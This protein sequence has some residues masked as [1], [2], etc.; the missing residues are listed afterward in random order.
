MLMYQNDSFQTLT[1]T[2]QVGLLILSLVLL[3][4]TLWI[5]YRITKNR[6]LSIRLLVA[7][8]IFWLFLWLSPQIY[9]AYYQILCP[10]S[11]ANED[12]NRNP[13]DTDR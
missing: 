4:C 3:T 9:Y 8:I 13:P 5:T 10:A 12:P 11:R 2:Q 6:S 1:L 7:V